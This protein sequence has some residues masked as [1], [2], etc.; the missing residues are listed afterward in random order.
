MSLWRYVFIIN[1]LTNITCCHL[2]LSQQVYY[3]LGEMARKADFARFLQRKPTPDESRWLKDVFFGRATY[4]GWGEEK[5]KRE[6]HH[7]SYTVYCSLPCYFFGSFFSVPNGRKGFSAKYM[8]KCYGN[9][10]TERKLL[11]REPQHAPRGRVHDWT[12]R[13]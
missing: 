8:I 9:F 2:P 1:T 6:H 7:S 11:C 10:I 12:Q 5:K 3:E 4:F 13:R